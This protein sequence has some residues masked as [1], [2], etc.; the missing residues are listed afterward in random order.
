MWGWCP[1]WGTVKDNVPLQKRRGG[2]YCLLGLAGLWGRLTSPDEDGHFP[3]CRSP[4]IPPPTFP[5]HWAGRGVAR[6]GGDMA[7][8]RRVHTVTSFSL[9]FPGFLRIPKHTRKSN[10]KQNP[11]YS[12]RAPLKREV[13]Y[14]RVRIQAGCRG[15]RDYTCLRLSLLCGKVYR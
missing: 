4:P 15:D 7:W 13:L 9:V 12:A 14:A 8:A 11:L 1:G 3:G 2:Q 6:N 5:K 10:K